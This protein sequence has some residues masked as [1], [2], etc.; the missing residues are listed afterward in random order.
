MAETVQV[1][2]VDVVIAVAGSMLMESM[3]GVA[4]STVML[5][6]AVSLAPLVST[7]VTVQVMVSPG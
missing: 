3:L 6:F 5:T 7:A 1:R 4:F 2:C